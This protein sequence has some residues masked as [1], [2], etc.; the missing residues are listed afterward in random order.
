MVEEMLTARGI[1]VTYETN[2]AMGHEMQPRFARHIRRRA[3][4]RGDKWHLDEV[5]LSSVGKKHSS[6]KPARGSIQ[7]GETVHPK[8]RTPVS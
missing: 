6:G 4:C 1:S 3:P 2:P 8:G 5:V 7:I